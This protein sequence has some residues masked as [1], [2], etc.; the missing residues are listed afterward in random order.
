MTAGQNQLSDIERQFAARTLVC[1]YD[2]AG[3]GASDP[4][5]RTPR[6]VRELV[7]DL[8][9]FAA[10]ARAAPP[11][12]LVGQSMGGNVV[13]AYAQAHPQ[14]V[15]GFVAMNPV[16]PAETWLRAAKKAMTK[17]EFADER[18]FYRGERGND[19]STSFLDP[20]LSNPLPS[21]MPYTIVYDDD[22]NGDSFCRRIV[23]AETESTKSLAAVGDGGRFLHVKGAGHEIFTGNPELVQKT[24]NDVLN[25]AR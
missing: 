5:A 6:S 9:A 11:Y 12:L 20:V 15:A 22:C 13:F 7:G 1:A 18:S 24:I 17:R 19:E 23:K 2:R 4:P 21:R 16:P 10:A 3:V 14:K 8:D 25:K